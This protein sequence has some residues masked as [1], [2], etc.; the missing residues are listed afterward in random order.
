VKPVVQDLLD[1]WEAAW[2]GHDQHAF[3]AVCATDLFYE[4]PVAR[5][6]IDGPE[7][8]GL[9]ARRLWDLVPDA[10]MT[11]AGARLGDGRY[12]AAPFL[13]TGTHTGSLDSLPAT[14][15]PIRVHGVAYCELDPPRERLW[16]VRIFFDRYDAAV[17]LGVLPEPGGIAERAMLAARGFGLRI[18]RRF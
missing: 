13:L 1:R 18:G 12:L 9:H 7:A 16:R 11:R 5:G 4:D 3:H 10:T 2:S 6:P 14:G 17:Q 15:K 8:L